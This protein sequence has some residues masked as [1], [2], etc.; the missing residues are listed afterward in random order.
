[1]STQPQNDTSRVT[2][3][4]AV[5]TDQLFMGLCTR[6][7]RDDG[8]LAFGISERDILSKGQMTVAEWR[9]RQVDLRGHAEPLGLELVSYQHNGETWWCVRSLFAVPPELDEKEMAVLAVFFY[10]TAADQ[11]TVPSHA[12]STPIDSMKA[13][14][15]EGDYMSS[16]AFD[17]VL[18]QLQEKG[19]IRRSR[20]DIHAETRLL[21]EVPEENRKYLADQV[22]RMIV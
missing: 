5:P 2:P 1:M 14:L 13:L 18:R 15:V 7:R 9:E 22:A 11:D 21:L 17:R 12:L 3:T 20:R 6:W 4:N 19:Y 10:R 8:S 16:Y